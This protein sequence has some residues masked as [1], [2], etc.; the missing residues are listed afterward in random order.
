MAIANLYHVPKDPG[1]W[2]PWGFANMAHHR[3]IIRTVKTRYGTELREYAAGVFNPK[4]LQPWLEQ[5]YNMHQEM[6]DVLGIAGFDLT[7]LDLK[8][9]DKV[10]DWVNKHA[11][12]HYQAATIL[13]VS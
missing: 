2:G 12:E 1:D 13:G 9:P 8:D 7:E 10:A 3:D 5:H 11:S 6:D 4:N